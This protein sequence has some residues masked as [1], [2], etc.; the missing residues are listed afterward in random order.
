MY[1]D[2]IYN[3][4]TTKINAHTNYKF[5]GGF[6]PLKSPLIYATVS[7]C[8]DFRHLPEIVDIYDIYA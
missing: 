7:R 2:I 1:D 8:P 3:I 4:I 5:Q 6:E